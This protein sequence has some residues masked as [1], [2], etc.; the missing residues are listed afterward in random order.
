MLIDELTGDKIYFKLQF[1]NPTMVSTGLIKDKLVATILDEYF[2]CSSDSS[3]WIERG[4]EIQTV[5]PKLIA[6]EE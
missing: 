3:K 5:L 6:G 4:T 1:E 2:F